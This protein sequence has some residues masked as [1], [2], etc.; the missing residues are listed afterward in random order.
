MM[1]PD[2]PLIYE[3]SGLAFIQELL[4]GKY[5]PTNVRSTPIIFATALW[6]MNATKTEPNDRPIQIAIHD[7][8]R[9]MGIK[10][11]IY[12]IKP[13]TSEDLVAKVN[14]ALGHGR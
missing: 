11:P 9:A 8:V 5:A 14:K 13:F 4:D 3:E 12:L 2:S 7:I 1:D 6:D 10:D